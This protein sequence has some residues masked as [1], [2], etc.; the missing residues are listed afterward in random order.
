MR[1]TEYAAC[2]I[3]VTNGRGK[4]VEG[5]KGIGCPLR[6]PI[7]L[8]EFGPFGSLQHQLNSLMWKIKL[9]ISLRPCV[10]IVK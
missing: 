10:N 4:G 5:G 7:N 2:K 6:Q 3:G 1:Q 8:N 9:C